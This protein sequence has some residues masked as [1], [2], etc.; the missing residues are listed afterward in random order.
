[1]I[2]NRTD[3][4]RIQD[5]E[6]LIAEDEPVFLLRCKDKLS[7]G[8]TKL[9]SLLYVIAH[10]ESTDHI[11]DVIDGIVDS[12]QDHVETTCSMSATTEEVYDSVGRFVDDMKNWQSKNGHQ[13]P[14]VPVKSLL[15]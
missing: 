2:H 5:P 15:G 3:Y 4:N 6:G 10:D 12:L 11:D 14:T 8:M 9:W 1:M 13:I 7:P